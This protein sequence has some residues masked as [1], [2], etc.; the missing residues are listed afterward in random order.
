MLSSVKKIAASKDLTIFT[1]LSGKLTRYHH[2]PLGSHWQL[3]LEQ[4]S[5]TALLLFYLLLSLFNVLSVIISGIGYLR[6]G[7]CNH[8]NKPP[9][10]GDKQHMSTHRCCQASAQLGSS[11]QSVW[12]CTKRTDISLL[13]LFI[14]ILFHFILTCIC[15]FL[16]FFCNIYWTWIDNAEFY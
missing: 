8:S 14:F 7:V 10:F 5:L 11:D 4:I 16:F 12:S 13:L 9:L 1:S 3:E 2:I 15:F 6:V